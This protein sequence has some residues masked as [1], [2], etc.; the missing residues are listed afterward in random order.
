MKHLIPLALAALL[1]AQPGAAAELRSSRADQRSLALTVYNNDL[2]LVRDGRTVTLPAGESVLAFQ[3]V[4]AQIRAE[5]A[6][7]YSTAP[8]A[9]VEQNF[10]FDLLSPRKLLEKYVGRELRLVRIHPTTDQEKE[11]RGTLL[12][13]TDGGVVF[14]I[15]ERI[16]TGGEHSPWRFVFDE[17]PANLRER[18]T[19]SMTLAADNGGRRDL[20]LAYLTGGVSWRSD[21]VATLAGD[22]RTLDLTGWVT[23][24]N[25]SGVGYPDAHLQLLAGDV[26]QAPPEVTMHD[27]YLPAP[28][29]T[30]SLAMP[31][32]EALFDYHLYT[33]AR[34][35]TLADNQTKQVLLLQAGDVPVAKEYR[36]DAG[37]WN[38]FLTPQEGKRELKSEIYLSFANAKPALGQPLPKGIVRFYKRDGRGDLQF[39]GEN[40]LDHTPE[41]REVRLKVGAA[42]D[43]TASRR[44]SDFKKVSDDVRESA[45]KVELFNAKEER[46]EVKV[47]EH[48]GRDWEVLQESAPHE[49]EDGGSVAWTVKLPAKGQAELIYRL[50][51]Q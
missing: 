6:R 2:A 34:P 35:T 38:G 16:E 15:G 48:P 36:F 33:V 11:E 44:Q 46:V 26:Q 19:L 41:G 42:F 50:R 29:M 47:V 39:I 10:D 37:D 25:R 30:K 31:K 22:D 43:L 17:V 8:L 5:S 27:P 51:V 4:A 12:S 18:P 49:K 24:T 45:W 21:Y 13:V 9:V 1:A 7:L 14:R 20:Q 23:L 32:Q 40:R 3:D 28:A